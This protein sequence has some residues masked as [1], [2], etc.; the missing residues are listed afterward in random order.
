MTSN[1][2]YWAISDHPITGFRLHVAT[3]AH[4]ANEIYPTVT[5]NRRGEVLFLWQIGPMSTS[6]TA[7]VKWARYNIDGT[8][9]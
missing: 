4:E 5:A 3:P 9:I 7:T 6:G 1:R 2:V 8:Y